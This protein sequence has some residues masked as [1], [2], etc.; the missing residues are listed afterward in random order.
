M[1]YASTL[2][3]SEQLMYS[4]IRIECS[5]DLG[6]SSTG[7]GFNF[8]YQVNEKLKCPVI[9]TN[10]H[11]IANMTKA[12]LVFCLRDSDGKPLDTHH[13]NLTVDNLQSH[14]IMHPDANVD[15]CALPTGSLDEFFAKQNL[16]VFNIA[17]DETLI[18]TQ[19]QLEELNP[20]EKIIMIGYPNGLWDFVNNKPIFRNGFT[21]THP[22]MN[23]CGKQEFLIDAACFPG[24]SGS[25]VLLFEPTSHA[26]KNGGLVLSPRVYLLGLLFA[27]PQYTAD[28]E[29]KIVDVPTTQKPISSTPLMINLG[30]VLKAERILEL[31]GLLGIA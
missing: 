20:I 17:L 1:S 28:G 12:V 24:S 2:S 10:K 4:T 18:P 7:T 5:N 19:A 29:I 14:L 25:P 15:L 8:S 31:R 11:V 3:P 26:P 27:G 30:F 13:Y 9:L 21:A 16:K 6:Q 23:Y 22:A